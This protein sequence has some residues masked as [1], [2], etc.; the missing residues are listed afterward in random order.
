MSLKIKLQL[1]YRKVQFPELELFA[2]N[3]KKEKED[4]DFTIVLLGDAYKEMDINNSWNYKDEERDNITLECL[5]VTLKEDS[6]QEWKI[7]QK[8]NPIIQEYRHPYVTLVKEKRRTQ[9]Q[10]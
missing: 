2:E 8:Y 3:F 1:D 4:E 6:Y 9:A 5:F 10:R 7:G